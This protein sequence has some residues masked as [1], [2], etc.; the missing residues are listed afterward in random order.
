MFHALY[1]KEKRQWK[2]RG[3]KKKVGG[4]N[5]KI[6]RRNIFFPYNITFFLC[7]GSFIIIF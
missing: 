2:G 6:L 1:E 4:Y 7:F 3:V 5:R